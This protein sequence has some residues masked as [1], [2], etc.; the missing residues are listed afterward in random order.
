[1]K[2]WIREW[3]AELRVVFALIG[4]NL[5]FRLAHR[6]DFLSSIAAS[7][8][9]TAASF[10]FLPLLFARAPRLGDWSPAEVVFLY[11]FSLVPLGLFNSVAMNLYEF[12]EKVVFEGRFDRLLLRPQSTMVQVLFDTMRVE[13]I[14]ECVIGVALV[15]WAS[16]RVGIVWG[17]GRIFAFVL[18]T[19][20]G[21]LLYVAIFSALTAASFRFEDRVGVVPPVYNLLNFSRY[22][23]TIYSIWIRFLLST[24]IPF[25]FASFYPGTRLLG[26]HD[27]TPYAMTAPFVSITALAL[28][29]RL[30]TREVRRYA[31]TGT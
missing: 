28:A 11:G 30:W 21:A 12:P 15:A 22:P 17:P 19:L 2:P 26:R 25:G 10:A 18:F 13:S 6:A 3:I 24:V 20:S 7:A 14:Q 5:R 1:V 23:M 9:G 29:S 4:V 8:L 16:P 27:W 31:G